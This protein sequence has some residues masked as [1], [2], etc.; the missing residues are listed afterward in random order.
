MSGTTR[1]IWVAFLILVVAAWVLF[2]F[3]DRDPDSEGGGL[4]ALMGFGLLGLMVVGTMI[5]ML[6]RPKRKHARGFDV[7]PPS[8]SA[9]GVGRADEP[10]G[11][12]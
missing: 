7:L 4:C 11:R 3:I 12:N 5:E 10:A 9:A 2:T 6:T 1:F 8:E